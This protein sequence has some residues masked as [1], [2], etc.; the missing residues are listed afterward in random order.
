MNDLKA[1]LLIANNFLKSKTFT[2]NISNKKFSIANC[3]I[4]I[5]LS[6]KQRDFYMRRNIHAIE[7]SLILSKSKV[8][9]STK[10]FISNDGDFLFESIKKAN[11]ILFH[12]ILNFHINEIVIRNDSFNTVKNLKNFCLKTVVEMIYDDCF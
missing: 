1:Y 2:I 7:F 8:K 12:H 11:F 3:K 10:F 5:N 9:L 4:V 6:I